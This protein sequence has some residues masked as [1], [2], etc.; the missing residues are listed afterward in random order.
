M[1]AAL[2]WAWYN[3]IMLPCKLTV[4][5]RQNQLGIFPVSEKAGV[6]GWHLHKMYADN[7]LCIICIKL[8]AAPQPMP[9]AESNQVHTSLPRPHNRLGAVG[10]GGI[11]SNPGV[12][13]PSIYDSST[14]GVINVSTS[15]RFMN[16]DGFPK[17][18]EDF[19]DHVTS[20]P[21]EALAS[22][23]NAEF[24]RTIDSVTPSRPCPRNGADQSSCFAEE[25]RAMR[26][27]G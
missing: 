3:S 6:G 17:A 10:H 22:R 1:F 25:L 14:G 11:F 8:T 26:P 9:Q 23:W 21:V 16:P 19:L 13:G 5:L 7:L 2:S 24:S 18:G 12:L 4:S 15:E 20:A 27:L